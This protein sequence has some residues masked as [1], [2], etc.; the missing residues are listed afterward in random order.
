MQVGGLLTA[1][2]ARSMICSDR[3]SGVWGSEGDH[4]ASADRLLHG[5]GK[6]GNWLMVSR[7]GSA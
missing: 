7:G 2:S 4:A 5:A 1:I 3:P 6:S